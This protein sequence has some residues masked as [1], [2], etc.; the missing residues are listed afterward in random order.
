MLYP[1][2][3]AIGLESEGWGHP[4]K[5]KDDSLAVTGK[6]PMTDVFCEPPQSI[7]KAQRP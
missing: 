7:S 3:N 4:V 6:E 5:P 2:A 1:P